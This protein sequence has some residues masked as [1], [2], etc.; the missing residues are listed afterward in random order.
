MRKVAIIGSHGYRANY[1]GWDQLVNNLVDRKSD[2]VKYY[3]F[4]P[5]NNP[6]S[7][8]INECIF[9][10]IPLP[11]NGV[12]GLVYDFI[13]VLKACILGIDTYLLLGL[14]PVPI[15]SIIKVFNP[16]AKLIVNIGGI[17]WERPQFGF[18]ARKY[19][20]YCFDLALSK[21]DSVILDSLHY[22]SL[23]STN[24]SISADISIIPYGG[25]IDTS[26][27]VANENLGVY[28]FLKSKYFL[29]I[30]RSI[31]DNELFELCNVFSEM[32]DKSLVLMSNFSNS[33][34]GKNILK[35]FSCFRN[36]YLVDGIYS[37]PMVDLIRRN[38]FAYIHT[39]TL[40]GSAPSLIEI[41]CCGKF[42]ISIDKPQNRF[43]L[44]N[45]GCFYK[46]YDELFELLK[47]FD[48]PVDFVYDK[49][50]VGKYKWNNVVNKYELLYS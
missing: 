39:H 1:G 36:I 20:R 6:S 2:N 5:F 35:K 13:S 43:T 22:K 14:G 19:L 44:D 50:R 28:S 32:P 21:F 30:S 10:Q 42:V 27:P 24:K 38:C 18:L 33:E 47:N 23:I 34:Y 49:S 31:V 8:K 9:I 40:C 25:E 48:I 37:K 17:E 26:L 45:V 11:A 41:I 4:S 12:F 16:N 7:C 15:A 29:S 46:S 3:I